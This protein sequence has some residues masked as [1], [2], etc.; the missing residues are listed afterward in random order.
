MPKSPK[1]SYFVNLGG[2]SI[3]RLWT[4]SVI[5][6]LSLFRPPKDSDP[7]LDQ[8]RQQLVDRAPLSADGDF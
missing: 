2:F 7:I 3:P 5:F 8:P 1:L 6:N 4:K